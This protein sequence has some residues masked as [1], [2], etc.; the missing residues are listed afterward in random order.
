MRKFLP[1]FLLFSS[2]ILMAQSNPV[3]IIYQPLL[4]ASV[5][6]GHSALALKVR[7][8]G[9]QSSSVV[10]WNGKPLKTKLRQ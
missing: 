6:P 1:L 9:F 7:G 10:D 2:G 8:T 3:P 5:A 4:P